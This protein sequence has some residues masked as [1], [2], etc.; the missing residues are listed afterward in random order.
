[1]GDLLTL[2]NFFTLM[3]LILLQAVLG[4]DNLLYI[5]I[6][7][8]RVDSA[9]QSSVRR[10]GIGIAIGLRLI[11]LLLVMFA[12]EKLNTPFFELHQ[13]GVFEVDVNIH[14]FIVL[15]GG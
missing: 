3:M 6:E 1:M 4:F 13:K 10:W 12:I 11:L 9:K 7:S 8:K 14:A 2:S 5:S 15:L